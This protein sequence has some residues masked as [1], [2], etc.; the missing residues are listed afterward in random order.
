MNY[1]SVTV[2]QKHSKKGRQLQK[3]QKQEA[4][5]NQVVPEETTDGDMRDW[6]FAQYFDF[7]ITTLIPDIIFLTFLNYFKLPTDFNFVLI[8]EQ[9]QCSTDW[10]G[11]QEQ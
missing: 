11:K 5:P 4:L 1:I 10:A 3:R 9:S 6:F 2:V 7:I 8:R